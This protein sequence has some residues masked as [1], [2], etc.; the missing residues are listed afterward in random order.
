MEIHG[1]EIAASIYDELRKKVTLLK[2]KGITPHLV[3]ILVGE[4]PSSIAYV[5]QKKKWAE[6]IGA[7][8]V[9][10]EYPEEITQ[11]ILEKRIMELNQ[12]DSVHAILVQIPLPPHLDAN[13]LTG[14]V[15]P[16]KDIDGFHKDSPF[17]PPLAVAVITILN[18][19]YSSS[20][21]QSQVQDG[22][23]QSDELRSEDRFTPCSNNIFLDWLQT[24]NIVVLG[25]GKAGGMPVHN[26][27][28]AKGIEHRVI[29][30]KTEHREALMKEA[31]IIISAV[32]KRH[33][34]TSD[35]I[36]QGV[37]LIGVGM[38]L[39]ENKK[40]FGDYDAEEIKDKASY[41]TPTPGGVGPVNVACLLKNLITA[42]EYS[43]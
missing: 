43:I 37:I 19:I 15:A 6:F 4:N 38:N 42:A 8:V 9:I 21:E 13:K 25:K 24:K 18:E 39:D 10:E 22:T 1:K 27:L 26:L 40:L 23:W 14:M 32:G 5:N 20:K 31:D 28:R 29:D 11:D 35:S 12:W 2:E 16:E 33:V 34:V 3:V 41:Y 17:T 30:S 36:K 7:T